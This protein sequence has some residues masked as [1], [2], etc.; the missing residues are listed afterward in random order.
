M[1]VI[2]DI[3]KYLIFMVL[4]TSVIGVGCS[5]NKTVYENGT[6]NSEQTVQ[7]LMSTNNWCMVESATRN[8]HIV[9]EYR[10]TDDSTSEGKR[11][12]GYSS[13]VWVDTILDTVQFFNESK[14]FR[15]S[16]GSKSHG[17]SI[18]TV[19][20]DDIKRLDSF[21]QTEYFSKEKMEAKEFAPKAAIVLTA[22]SMLSGEQ[23]RELFPCSSISEKLNSE[24]KERRP[25]YEYEFMFKRLLHGKFGPY[26]ILI[27]ELP[28]TFK[29]IK[30]EDIDS[31]NWCSWADRGP[32]TSDI[33][34]FS[35]KDNAIY[36]EDYFN[37]QL[38]SGLEDRYN[39]DRQALIESNPNFA[40]D[41]K[42]KG[43]YHVE[44]NKLFVEFPERDFMNN[45]YSLAVDSDGRKMLVSM[46]EIGSSL[47]GVDNSKISTILFDCEESKEDIS[48][49]LINIKESLPLLIKRHESFL[50]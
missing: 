7:S 27:A 39:G 23:K 3:K 10:F 28:F 43:S 25:S 17:V 44:E 6:D 4:S 48:S 16:A 35:F 12:M 50:N 41:S 11:G 5:R 13:R 36:Y 31:T 9:T 45:K 15:W 47:D 30:V 42:G 8:T 38:G 19:N 14:S 29:D 32:M 2:S 18:S 1:F 40:F 26:S 34:V 21:S 24:K 20:E 46:F 37:S 22:D 49:S 33:H